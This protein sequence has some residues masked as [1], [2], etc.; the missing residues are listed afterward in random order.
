MKKLYCIDK[1]FLN[2][3]KSISQKLK[4]V[5]YLQKRLIYIF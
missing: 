4:K 2:L 3:I 1:I 5:L